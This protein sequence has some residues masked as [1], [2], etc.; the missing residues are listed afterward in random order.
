LEGQYVLKDLV[1]VAAGLV[2]GAQALSARLVA[3]EAQT[4]RPAAT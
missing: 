1:L 3:D 4:R 2:I